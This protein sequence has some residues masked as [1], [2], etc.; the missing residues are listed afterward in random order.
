MTDLVPKIAVNGSDLKAVQRFNRK[1][2][3]LPRFRMRTRFS[4]M[5]IQALLRMS[6]VGANRR[7]AKAGVTVSM[8]VA[9]YD[10]LRVPV[11][12]IRPAGRVR[13]LVLDLHG[14]GW[15]IGNPHMNDVHN[16]AMAKACQVAVVSVDYRLLPKA[17][18]QDAMDDCLAAARW[19]LSGG[20]SD[21]ARLPV[22]I[23]GESAGAHLA[24]TVLQ[25]LQGE[26][27]WLA[28]VKGAVLYYGVYDLAGTPSVRAA[29]ADTLVLH[30][31][32]LAQALCLLLPAC[33]E[34][35]RR[36][37]SYSPLY[38][39]LAGMPPALMF[40]G[41]KDPL[42][43]DTLLFAQRW[44]AVADTELHVLPEAPHGYLH[45]PTPLARIVP[46]RTHAWIN[47]R[48]AALNA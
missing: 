30:G 29:A 4:P 41:E 20:I 45:F 48:L 21:T 43:D 47:D 7:L 25:R 40:G 15:V 37:P 2:R 1:L 13:A 34:A 16:A 18:L 31:P 8:H 44:Q 26:P 9:E 27:S 5:L 22:F 36:D 35:H 33:D 28:R 32:T 17:T 11:R 10:G 6:Q 23:V 19:L 3:H 24:A 39:E 12:V 46:A 42:L 14:G 38:G